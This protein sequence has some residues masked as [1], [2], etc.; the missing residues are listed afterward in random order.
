MINESFDKPAAITAQG[1][2]LM[3]DGKVL[4]REF[5][6]NSFQEAFGF[7]T[8]VA[9]IAENLNHHPDWH[10][11]YH[12]VTIKLTTHDVDG[13][14]KLDLKMAKR[15]NEVYAIWGRHLGPQELR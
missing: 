5:T 14:S 10:N 12:L 7:M 9:L 1:W 8:Q 13:L 2:Y 11:V 6:F 4:E 3:N 15:I